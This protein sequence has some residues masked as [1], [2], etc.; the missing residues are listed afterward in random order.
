MAFW[1]F[2]DEG[3][4]LHYDAWLPDLALYTDKLY[5][6]DPNPSSKALVIDGLCTQAQSVCTG[7]NQQ[8][9]STAGCVASM[10]AKPYGS[11]DEVWGDNV[12][13]RTLHLLLAKIR[14]EVRPIALPVTQF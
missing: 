12:V 7:A 8:Y 1:R 4:V 5:G 11:W 10:T 3:A 6:V 13:C 9:N 2:D 14:P